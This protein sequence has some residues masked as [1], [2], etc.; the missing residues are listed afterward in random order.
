MN[1]QFISD[2]KG[3]TTGVFIPI[4]DWKNLKKRYEELEQEESRL[5]DVPEWHKAIVRERLKEY[6]ENP[7]NLMDWED[8]KE[9]FKFE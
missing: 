2:S 8:V 7:D 9:D 4:Q 6:K 5:L 3:R 1:L